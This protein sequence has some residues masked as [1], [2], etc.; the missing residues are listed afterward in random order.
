MV[1]SERGQMSGR[2]GGRTVGGLGPRLERSELLAVIAAGRVDVPER[3][4][5]PGWKGA[6]TSGQREGSAPQDSTW[7]SPAQPM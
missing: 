2:E 6:R 4:G 7:S 3:T 5:G 1:S